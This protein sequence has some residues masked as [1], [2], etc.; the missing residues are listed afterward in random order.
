V[1]FTAKIAPLSE[2]MDPRNKAFLS[3]HIAIVF[4]GFTAILGDLISLS[5][6]PLVWWRLLLAVLAFV[7][8]LIV[9]KVFQWPGFRPVRGTLI[10]VSVFLAL[11]WVTFFTSIKLANASIGVLCLATTSF[12]T[13]IIEPIITKRPFRLL[14]MIFGLLILPGMLLVVS[15]V[16]ASMYLGIVFGLISALMAA[17]FTTYNK[18]IVGKGSTMFFTFVELLFAFVFISILILIGLAFYDSIWLWPV[19]LVDWKYLLILAVVCTTLSYTLAFD[20]LKHM[21][22]FTANLSVN[23]EPVYGIL[24]A[25]WILNENEVLNLKFYV[26]AGLIL[27][28]VFIFPIFEK[29]LLKQKLRKPGALVN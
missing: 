10:M 12:M 23:L 14:E 17:V 1:I 18:S 2:L 13:S 19:P 28:V 27:V 4:Y 29:K 3:L 9:R 5:P 21:T 8:L 26:G 24:L 6:L 15:S 25:A 20:A 7:P 22:A 11:H 16:D